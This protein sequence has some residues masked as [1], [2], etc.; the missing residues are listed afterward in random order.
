[1]CYLSN[2]KAGQPCEAPGCER[3]MCSRWLAA[4]R[5]CTRLTCQEYFNVGKGKAVAAEKAEEELNHK[6]KREAAAQPSCGPLKVGE[7]VLDLPPWA[8]TYFDELEHESLHGSSLVTSLPFTVTN[9]RR[10]EFEGTLDYSFL[11][12]GS[13]NGSCND[14]SRQVQVQTRWVSLGVTDNGGTGF[15]AAAAALDF[16]ELN[17]ADGQDVADLG[18]RFR[19]W[20]DEQWEKKTSPKGSVFYYNTALKESTWEEPQRYW[21]PDRVDSLGCRGCD[22]VLY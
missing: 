2:R 3:T 9:V 1:M 22:V 15:E 6:R 19:S 13:F 17:G 18:S 20:I 16:M 11:V 14:G 7:T 21:D 10:D 12:F 8:G 5:C 4:G